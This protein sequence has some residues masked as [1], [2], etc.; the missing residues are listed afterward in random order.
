LRSESANPQQ[1]DS[2]TSRHANPE[3]R[4][5]LDNMSR[6]ALRRSAAQILAPLQRALNSWSSQRRN[7]SVTTVVLYDNLPVSQY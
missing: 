3:G 1:I 2:A 4:W 7:W 5:V 6:A